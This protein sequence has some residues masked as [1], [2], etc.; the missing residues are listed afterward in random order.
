MQGHSQ[1]SVQSFQSSKRTFSRSS[2]AAL[3]CAT[4]FATDS[5]V[6]FKIYRLLLYGML[7]IVQLCL[8]T[9]IVIEQFASR[10]TC[11]PRAFRTAFW[12]RALRTTT[13]SSAS[14]SL[15]ATSLQRTR[16]TTRWM[17]R[18]LAIFL[19]SFLGDAGQA[20]KVRAYQLPPRLIFKNQLLNGLPYLQHQGSSCR[21]EHGQ[22]PAG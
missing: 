22:L 8:H 7:S 1:D 21:R 3:M 4:I 19:L 10:T 20:S 16:P 15:S 18:L 17:P 5:F 13:S 6:S 11:L 9:I 12:T 14:K 2:F